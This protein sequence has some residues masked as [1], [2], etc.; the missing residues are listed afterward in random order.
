MIQGMALP[1]TSL[2][3]KEGEEMQN[4]YRFAGMRAN[5]NAIGWM[6]DKKPMDGCIM[7]IYV[8]YVLILD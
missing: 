8:V 3:L 1:P 6:E 4:L 7:P 2:F 5:A